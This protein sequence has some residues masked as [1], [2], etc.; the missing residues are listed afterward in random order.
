MI[1]RVLIKIF[2]CKAIINYIDK[3]EIFRAYSKD[4]EVLPEDTFILF[5]M[6]AM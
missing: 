2:Q 1:G 6:L 4:R 5:A 3:D